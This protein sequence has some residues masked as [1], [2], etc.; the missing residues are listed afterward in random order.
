MN[1]VQTKYKHEHSSLYAYL[2]FAE[3]TRF[4]ADGL[5]T[6]AGVG[7]TTRVSGPEDVIV[8]G[9]L[10]VVPAADATVAVHCPVSCFLNW[11]I[12][13]DVIAGNTHT[14]CKYHCLKPKKTK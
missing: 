9:E 10:A 5:N 1:K 3:W 11:S 2:D 6:T 12:V 7:V 14:N 8:H 4:T 13:H